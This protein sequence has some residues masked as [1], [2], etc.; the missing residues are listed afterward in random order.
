MGGRREVFG[1]SSCGGGRSMISVCS[2]L[3]RTALSW[4]RAVGTAGLAFI[5][6]C[7]DPVA[8]PGGRP[9]GVRPD[10]RSWAAGNALANLDARGN[11]V[12]PEPDSCGRC[13][14]LDRAVLLAQGYVRTFL[15]ESAPVPPLG[16]S[17]KEYL[18]QIHGA[19][20]D[21]SAIRPDRQQ[22]F[23]A[24]TPYILEG[25]LPGPLNV[26]LADMVFVP[27]KV[28]GWTVA[29]LAV[30]RH[31][32]DVSIDLNGRLVFPV[33]YGG[34]FST[35]GVPRTFGSRTIPVWP[36]EAVE[37]VGRHT[38]AKVIEV[39]R[40][41]RPAARVA[42]RFALW[43]MR[44]DRDIMMRVVDSGL[45][46]TTR[47]VYVGIGSDAQ[48]TLFLPRPPYPERE[49]FHY[50]GE[51]GD[52]LFVVPLAADIPTRFVQVVPFR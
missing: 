4:C 11:F 10:V 29:T 22:T 25:D 1:L 52:S 44:L 27:L 13:V 43:E 30:S 50:S 47:L 16:S 37:V 35:G 38:N 42:A 36:E 28:R 17:V 12:L 14:S 26:H 18:E 5:L 15:L 6:S 49:V 41:V 31:A 23:N 3:R 2:R 8:P 21:W 51:T 24:V 7:G 20:I 33:H 19:P 46:E 39:P 48:V 34:E 40:L 9:L 45:T 32:G